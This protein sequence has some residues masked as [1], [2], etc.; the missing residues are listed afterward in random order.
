MLTFSRKMGIVFMISNWGCLSCNLVM[1]TLFI[2]DIIQSVRLYL[3][4]LLTIIWPNWCHKHTLRS[5]ILQNNSI[6]HLKL[7]IRTQHTE[8]RA[9]FDIFLSV[10]S[11]DWKG[12]RALRCAQKHVYIQSEGWIPYISVKPFVTII[13][14]YR[15]SYPF[16]ISLFL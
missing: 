7:S 14:M 1:A 9:M 8:R 15:N 10:E 2:N 12:A 11:Y 16:V 4:Y 3:Q 13:C 5:F 6:C